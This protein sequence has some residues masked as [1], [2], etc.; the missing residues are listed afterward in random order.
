MDDPDTIQIIHESLENENR[1]QMTRQI[2]E[3]G[4]VDFFLDYKVFLDSFHSNSKTEE[5]FLK[6]VRF[7]DATISY[8]R[9]KAR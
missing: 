4:A 9:T 5:L 2:D 8:H 6:Y 1:D 7:A 3:Y